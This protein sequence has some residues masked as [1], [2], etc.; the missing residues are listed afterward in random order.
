MVHRFASG[1]KLNIGIVGATG[2][3]GSMIRSILAER[4]FPVGRGQLART[5]HLRGGQ[6][7]ITAA[8]AGQS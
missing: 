5:G 2:L 7:Q 3:V 4:N 8:G 1:Q 6:Q